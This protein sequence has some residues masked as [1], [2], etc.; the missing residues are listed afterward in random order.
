MSAP[1]PEC[2]QCGGTG[3]VDAEYQD[4]HPPAFKRCECVLKRDILQNTDRILVGLSKA[5][6]VN[7]SPLL[8]KEEEDLLVRAGPEFLSH[9]RHVAIRKPLTWRAKVVSDAELVTAW[10]AT[11]ALRGS[12][13]IDADAYKVSTK[14]LTIPDLVVPPD[15]LIVRLGVKAARN[16]AAPE[17]LAEALSTRLHEGKPTWL[18]DDP[19]LPLGPDHLMWNDQVSNLLRPWSEVRDLGESSVAAKQAQTAKARAGGRVRP[20]RKTLRGGG[21]E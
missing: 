2:P 3:F 11:I 4:P 9:L 5:P 8:G 15:L 19:R 12:D 18:W 1:D 6:P 7:S 10:L 13:I 16:Q 20:S 21:S 17:V 14:Y